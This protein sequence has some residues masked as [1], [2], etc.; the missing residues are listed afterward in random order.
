[1]SHNHST[2]IFIKL[3]GEGKKNKGAPGPRRKKEARTLRSLILL[4]QCSLN[5]GKGEDCKRPTPFPPTTLLSLVILEA[6]EK[7]ETH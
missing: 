5:N 3:K 7:I 2:S 1:M 6:V 4:M